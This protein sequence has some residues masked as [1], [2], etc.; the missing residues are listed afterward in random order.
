[1]ERG[2]RGR[3]GE[4]VA[5]KW[6]KRQGYKVVERNV[7]L[8]PYGELDIVAEKG[9]CLHFFEVRTA[10]RGS[11]VSPLESL[12]ASKLK[13]LLKAVEIFRL[14]RGLQGREYT[15]NLLAVEVGGEEV[16]SVEMVP[17]ILEEIG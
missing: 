5:A 16:V 1:M 10:R 4:E 7:N 17:H 15:V 14:R 11:P 2:E 9:G 12:S 8:L 3:L 6:L 13:K